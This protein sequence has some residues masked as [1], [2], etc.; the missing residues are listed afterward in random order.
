MNKVCEDIVH[1]AVKNEKDS[2]DSGP[3]AGSCVLM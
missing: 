1:M 3:F 2:G